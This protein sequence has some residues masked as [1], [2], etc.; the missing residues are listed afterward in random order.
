MSLVVK[1]DASKAQT[2]DGAQMS[3]LY[4]ITAQLVELNRAQLS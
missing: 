2:T 4:A 3:I 1:A